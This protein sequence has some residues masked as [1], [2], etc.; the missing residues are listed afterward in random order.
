M[1]RR[2]KRTVLLVIP[3]ALAAIVWWLV[4]PARLSPL[5]QSLVGRWSTTTDSHAFVLDLRANRQ[6]QFRSLDTEIGPGRVALDGKWRIKDGMLICDE[7]SG[8]QKLLPM[9]LTADGLRIA[10][11]PLPSLKWVGASEAEILVFK[12][13]EFT[14]QASGSTPRTWKRIKEPGQLP[15]PD[16]KP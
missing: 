2:T 14:V 6:F 13:D 4:A 16:Q 10:G 15:K 12:E 1:A 3:T 8:R 5:E 9:D 11:V 7:R